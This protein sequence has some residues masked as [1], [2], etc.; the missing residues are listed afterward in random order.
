[1][2]S[3]FLVT[4]VILSFLTC[5]ELVIAA[6]FALAIGCFYSVPVAL[7]FVGICFFIA[8]VATR[9]TQSA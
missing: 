6:V 2:L 9:G 3:G 8:V 5:K 1:M 4:L 7:L